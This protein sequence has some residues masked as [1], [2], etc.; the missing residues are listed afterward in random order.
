[1]IFFFAANDTRLFIKNGELSLM[2]ERRGTGPRTL[3]FAHGWISSRRMFYDVVERL[4][5]LAI[6]SFLL[7]FHG[8]GLSDRS[9]AGHD[10]EGYASDMRAALATLSGDVEL[11]AHSMGG[12]VAQYVALDPPPNLAR[13]VLVA[14]GAA[15]AM[16]AT[17]AHR[18]LSAAAY[19]S[20]ERIEAF[21][22]AAMT[23]RIS[24]EAVE[25]IVDDALIAERPAWFDWYETGRLT[26]FSARL[27]E[28]RTPALVV[29]GERDPLAPPARLRRDVAG[30]IPGAHLLT[31]KD[32]G[33]NIPVEA[34]RELA[35]IIERLPPV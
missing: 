24:L 25:R 16:P 27:A 15:K 9:P 23:R 4:D 26:D 14:P 35:Q 8:A 6:S 21:Q 17:E 19:G 11:I 20:R 31:L 33:H 1:M 12:K 10:L 30:A 22:R 34:P 7:D 29:A 28:I 32:V 2:L 18:K 13:L 3:L 5:P